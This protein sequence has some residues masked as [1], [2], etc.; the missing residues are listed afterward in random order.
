MWLSNTYAN[1]TGVF[2]VWNEETKTGIKGVMKHGLHAVRHIVAS[3]LLRTTGDIYL[4]AWAIQDS[5]RT[6][7]R[8]YA[9][10]IPRDKVRLAVAHLRRSR[11]LPTKGKPKIDRRVAITA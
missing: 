7:E 6:V 10:F 5:A 1:M 2:F 3:S 11:A 8:H 9:R 4:A